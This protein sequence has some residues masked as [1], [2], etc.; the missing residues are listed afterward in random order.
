MPSTTAGCRSASKRTCGACR[1]AR[2]SASRDQLVQPHVLGLAARLVAAREL[3]QVGDEHPQLGRLL[4]DVGQQPRALVGRQG[5]GLRQH[6]DVRAQA[7][8]R[9]AQL[10]RGVGDELALGGDR[11][12]E[13][14]EHGVE[15]LRELADLVV[16]GDLD[17]APEVLGGGDVAGGLGDR[18]DRRD[19]VAR[20][21]PPERDRE[22][23]AA[24][25]DEREHEPQPRE[26][27]VGG[28]QRAA[29]AGPRGRRPS[30]TVSTR[31]WLP[32]HARV[33]EVL[34]R[35]AG[36]DLTRA[37]LDRQRRPARCR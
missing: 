24:E 30:G 5:V 12:L 17:P 31:T 35:D 18:G 25:A 4:L 32:P 28:L 19:D 7:G 37:L 9:R 15:V 34:R 6:L 1:R 2:V 23:D 14:V 3:D 16:G 11:A 33:G 36:R 29:R 22:R 26:H 10:V 21:E 20:D 27:G 13:R 8:D